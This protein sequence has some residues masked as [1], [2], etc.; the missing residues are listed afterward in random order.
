MV[1]DRVGVVENQQRADIVWPQAFQQPVIRR[2]IIAA[3]RFL[4]F[5]PHE[6]HSHPAKAR[7]GDHL[8][9]ARLWIGEMNV[10]SQPMTESRP[11]GSRR[12]RAGAIVTRAIGRDREREEEGEQN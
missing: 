9:F 1:V 6:I 10:H 8:D 4:G 2:E 3:A 11:I 7:G 12:P 5:C